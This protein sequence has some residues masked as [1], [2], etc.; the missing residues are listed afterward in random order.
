MSFQSLTGISSI[1]IS[2]PTTQDSAAL[3]A[4]V[5]TCLVPEASSTSSF[6]VT[7]TSVTSQDR[8][9][10]LN[11]L[12][13]QRQ[14]V[15]SGVSVVFSV[16]FDVDKLNYLDASDGVNKMQTSFNTNAANGKFD[17]IL[18]NNAASGSPLQAV[19]GASSALVGATTIKI[20]QLMHPSVQPTVSCRP[21][22]RP[23]QSPTT[24]APTFMPT[25]KT[26]KFVSFI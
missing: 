24:A 9:L 8:R 6:N 4:T 21:T 13:R 7:V 5:K 18:R 12:L 10:E 15:L 22:V 20:I 17:S 16:S 14:D 26:S 1:A 11:S 23:T 2:S 25:I 3:I 19:S